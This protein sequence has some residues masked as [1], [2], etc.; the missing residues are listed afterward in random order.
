MSPLSYLQDGL[1]TFLKF[2]FTLLFFNVLR[3][4]F[5]DLNKKVQLFY[6]WEVMD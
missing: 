5:K 2:Q 3:P 4:Q 1:V 6:A